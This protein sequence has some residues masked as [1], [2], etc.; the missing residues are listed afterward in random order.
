MDQEKV[1]RIWNLF[2]RIF[3]KCMLVL[4]ETVLLAVFAL[5]CVMFVVAKGPSPT[6]RDLFVLSVRETSAAGFLADLFFTE[7]EIAAIENS[8]GQEE[9]EDTDTS[10]IVI[11]D[12]SK[13][14]SEDGPVADEWGLIDEDGDGLILESIKG[15]G[16]TGYML[17]VLDPSRVV[18]ASVP[19][20]FGKKGYTVEQMAQKYDAVAGINAGGFWDEGGKGHGDIPDSMVVYEGKIYHAE[21]GV[22]RK[23]GFVGI[24]DKNILHVGKFTAQDVKD[25]NIQYG[26]GFGP[27]LVSNGMPVQSS[28]SGL[29][30]R[31]AIGQ[32]S[33]GAMLL[34]V[35]DGRQATSLGV[36]YKD[37][38]EIFLSY[39]AVNACNLDGGS[40]SLMWYEGEYINNCASLLGIRPIPTTFLVLKQG[41]K[42]NG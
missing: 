26:V 35:I 18:M 8:G 36:T 34:L 22:G 5:Y 9:V 13:P 11:P 29:N 42:A 16:Y 3:G 20:D 23:D 37:L 28:N 38:S 10:L 12:E 24:D 40:S 14:N 32:R 41:A 25:K 31:T 1:K 15:E 17:V 30:P 7:E 19:E 39:G 33:D 2:L 4:A 6:A 21:K 27:V